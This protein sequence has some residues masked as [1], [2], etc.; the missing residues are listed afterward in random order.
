MA[1]LGP[2]I[3]PVAGPCC[4]CRKVQIRVGEKERSSDGVQASSAGS[5]EFQ[6]PVV[7]HLGPEE[8]QDV[9]V[10][11]KSGPECLPACKGLAR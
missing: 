5:V 9:H 3:H 1:A 11:G 2:F 8:S 7:I 6:T 4:C 10:L